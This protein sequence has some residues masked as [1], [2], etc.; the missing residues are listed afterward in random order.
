MWACDQHN[1]NK[2]S[3][4]EIPIL[5]QGFI[6]NEINLNSQ[7]NCRRTCQ[8]YDYTMQYNCNEG[9]YCSRNYWKK[10]SLCHGLVQNCIKMVDDMTICDA[11]SKNIAFK[12]IKLT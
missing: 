3:Y 2:D 5:Y 10:N 7:G 6:V 8:D 1:Y 4:E 12:K 11:V 9:T